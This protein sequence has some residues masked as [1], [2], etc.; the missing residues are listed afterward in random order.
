MPET[1]NGG[2]PRPRS[3][4]QWLATYEEWPAFDRLLFLNYGVKIVAVIRELADLSVADHLGD[5]ARTVGELAAETGTDADILYRVLRAAASVGLFEELPDGRWTNNEDSRYLISGGEYS[6]RDLV[7]FSGGT[8]LTS[9]YG[10]LGSTLRT[11]VPGFEHVNGAAFYEFM[12]SH[13]S[14]A[15]LFDKTMVQRSW[16]TAVTL[17]KKVDFT[18][19]SVITDIAGG[20]GHLIGEV[21]SRSPEITATLFERTAV[22]PHAKELLAKYG[23]ADRVTLVG[24]DYFGKLPGGAQA[25]FLNAVLNGL[26]DGDAQ[27]VLVNLRQT[28]GDDADA[29]VFICEKVLTATQNQWD[30]SKLIDLDLLLLTGGRERTYA[31]WNEL[32]TA[33]GFSLVSPA[34]EGT[35]PWTALECRPA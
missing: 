6:L 28:I 18:R 14:E 11:G 29:R 22:L 7:L 12:E 20:R 23:V 15:D 19:F 8:M 24:G 10:A 30:Y 34:P 16:L 5:G 26:T 13:P 25:Y 27:R 35:S 9:A 17:L 1:E 31:E 21:L 4:W 33:S 2:T 32:V 3:M